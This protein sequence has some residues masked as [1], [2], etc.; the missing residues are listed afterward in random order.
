[1]RHT[2]LVCLTLMSLSLAWTGRA[3][4]DAIGDDLQA[5]T[6]VGPKGEG[7]DAATAAIQRIEQANADA[8]TRILAAMDGANPLAVNWLRG[9]FESV[10]D[11][12][13]SETGTLPV[14]DL[15]AFL[16][17]TSHN[18]RARRLA[19]EWIIKADPAA[20]DRIIPEMISDP[21]AEMRRD[22]VARLIDEAE[23]LEADGKQDAARTTYGA[24]MQG[25]VDGD[26]VELL[27]KSLDKL[28]ASVD[29]VDHF[30]LVTEWKVIGPFD[31][32]GGIGFAAVYPPEEELNFDAEYEGQLGPVSWE[33]VQAPTPPDVYD[34][35]KVGRVDLAELTAPHKG[36]VTYTATGFVAAEAGPVEFRIGTPNAWKLWVNGKEV[37]GQEEYH[38]GMFFDQYSVQA[39]LQ[40]GENTILLKVCQNEQT[41][42]WAQDWAFQL[43]ICDLTGRG[44]NSAEERTAARV[45]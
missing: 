16:A 41:E 4:A 29:L 39:E 14:S 32:R 17:E 13:L 5:I 45:E 15:E 31:N 40:E 7:H 30:G 27:A 22:A 12:V 3:A 11:R 34:V 8:L 43:R 42:D 9:A 6:E 25:A 21:S 28:G 19:Y 38:R 18:P 33:P 35:G 36:A 2:V 44:L 23:Q 24:A 10:A 26:Q 1:M 37:F 20:A